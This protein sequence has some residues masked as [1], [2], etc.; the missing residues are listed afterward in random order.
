MQNNMT[1]YKKEHAWRLIYNRFSEL[2]PDQTFNWNGTSC[3][4]VCVLCF[5]MTDVFGFLGVDK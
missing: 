2:I 1:D 3:V 5:C 4:C